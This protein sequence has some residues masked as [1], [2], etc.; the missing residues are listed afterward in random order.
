MAKREPMTTDAERVGEIANN[1]SDLCATCGK[2]CQEHAGFLWPQDVRPL[3]FVTV[4]DLL[5]TGRYVIDWW[6]GDPRPEGELGCI[7]MIRPSHVGV[8]AMLDPSWGG[9]CTFLTSTGCEL[10]FDER[11]TECKAL[12]PVSVSE[13]GCHFVAEYD[14]KE[15]VAIAW[16]GHQELMQQVAEHAREAAAVMVP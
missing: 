16:A 9:A 8:A 12:L 10:A 13:G 14:G 6:E 5:S 7:Y 3:D 2:C 11:P 15:A 4:F 1:E